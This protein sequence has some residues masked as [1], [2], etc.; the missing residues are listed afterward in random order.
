MWSVGVIAYELCT[1]KS[2]FKRE[3]SKM[4][5][6]ELFNSISKGEYPAITERYSEEL[7]SLID[8]M[9]K[10][11]PGERLDLKQVVDLCILYAKMIAKRPKIDPFLIMDDIIEK[12]R[13]LDYE[14]SF[15]KV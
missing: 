6:Y 5:L 9:L 7:R 1:L 4:S 11:N 10:V 8:S 14:N 2:P 15:C 12:L 13:L 3:D